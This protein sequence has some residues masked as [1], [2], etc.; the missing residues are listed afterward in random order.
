MCQLIGIIAGLLIG[1]WANRQDELQDQE[2]Q[3]SKEI[4]SQVEGM[5]G[6]SKR[7]SHVEYEAFVLDLDEQPH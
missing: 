6:M 5:Y 4:V 3:T 7:P 1:W 2:N